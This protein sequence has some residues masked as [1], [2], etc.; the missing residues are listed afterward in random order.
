VFFWGV[1]T[2]ALASYLLLLFFFSIAKK[3]KV[4]ST[5]Q[6]VLGSLA[7]WTLCSLL[8]KLSVYPGEL[9]WNRMM[10]AFTFATPL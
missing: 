8:M 5:F 6:L 4:V 2:V 10:V 3:D 9:F 1:P 7:L